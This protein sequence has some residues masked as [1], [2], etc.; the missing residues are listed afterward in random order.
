MRWLTLYDAVSFS[1]TI[2]EQVVQ[3]TPE[4]PAAVGTISTTASTTFLS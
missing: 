3:L 1:G 2:P 4:K